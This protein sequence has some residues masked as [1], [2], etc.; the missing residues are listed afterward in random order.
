MVEEYLADDLVKDSDDE[1]RIEKA[2]KTAERKAS[3]RRKKCQVDSA[4]TRPRC[5]GQRFLLTGLPGAALGASNPASQGQQL[6]H[7]WR[8][9]APIPGSRPIG[10]CHYCGE[11]GHLNHYCPKGKQ[12]K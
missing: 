3:K 10:L 8:R 11:M 12:Q 1:P 6:S 9:Q 4:L 5:G 2:E 7:Q